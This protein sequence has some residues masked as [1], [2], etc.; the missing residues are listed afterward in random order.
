MRELTHLLNTDYGAIHRTLNRFHNL[1]K[2]KIAFKNLL[3]QMDNARLYSA[4]RIQTI[5]SRA[6]CRLFLKVPI[7]QI[8]TCVTDSSS[9]GYN[10]IAGK[11]NKAME[12][13]CILMQS[14]I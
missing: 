5:R 3:L 13:S 9:P 12:K 7:V 8:S 4:V 14:G 10:N 1:K 6:E 11:K 2:D